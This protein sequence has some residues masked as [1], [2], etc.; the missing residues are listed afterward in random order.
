M[1]GA[2][3]GSQEFQSRFG[4]NLTNNEFVTL[5]YF[6]VLRRQADET[7]FNFWVS[8]LNSGASRAQVA[9]S[10]LQSPQ[11]QA[12]TSSQNR[13]TVSLLYFEM[14]R[15]APDP[16]AFAYWLN[17]LNTGTPLTAILDGLLSTPEYAGRF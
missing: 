3:L 5:M 14:L 7:G 15:R 6:N 11:F 4:G 17:L 9:L 2:L 10:F 16:P 13:M 12:L 8:Q 1:V